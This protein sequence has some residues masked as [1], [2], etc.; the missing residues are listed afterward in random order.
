MIFEDPFTGLPIVAAGVTLEQVFLNLSIEEPPVHDS[1]TP[2][3]CSLCGPLLRDAIIAD[4][5]D[6]IAELPEA[7]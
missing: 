2:E 1:E 3:E 5:H 4:F 6:E 7:S